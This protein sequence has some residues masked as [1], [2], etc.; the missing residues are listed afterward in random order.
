MD[1]IRQGLAIAQNPKHNTWINPLLLLSD[2]ALG[3]LI[4]QKI[5]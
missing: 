2:A 4:I 1:L 5:P 3:L